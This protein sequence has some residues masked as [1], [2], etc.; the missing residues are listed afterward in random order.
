MIPV[1]AGLLVASIAHADEPQG[2]DSDQSSESTSDPVAIPRVE[3]SPDREDQQEDE[4]DASNQSDEDDPSD[5]DGETSS[6]GAVEVPAVEVEANE[7]TQQE[8]STRQPSATI[9][10]DDL[11]RRG[12]TDLEEAMRWLSAGTPTSPTDTGTGLIVDGLPASQVTVL[13]NGLPIS[14]K[15]GTRGGPMVDLSAI[16][17][18]PEAVERIEGYRGAGPAGSGGAGGVVINIVTRRERL[19]SVFGRARAGETGLQVHRRNFAAGFQLPIGDEWFVAAHGTRDFRGALDVNDDAVVD[20]PRDQGWSARAQAAWRPSKRESLRLRIDGSTRHSD[21][22]GAT[23]SPLYDRVATRTLGIRLQGD[24][25]PGG[26]WRIRHGTDVQLYDHTFHK[27]VR[28]SGVERLNAD[29]DQLRG[30]QNLVATRYFDN[31]D[32]NLELYGSGRRVRWAGES[33]RLAPVD[34][35]ALGLGVADTFYV[36]DAFRVSGRAYGDLAT[37]FGPGWTAELGAAVDVADGWTVKSTLSRTRRLPSAEELYLF[38]DH[39]DIGYQIRGNEALDPERLRSARLGISYRDTDRTIRARVGGFY[40]RS[41]DLV[42]TRS[43]GTTDGGVTILQYV[44][45]A[46]AHTAGVNATLKVEQLPGQVSLQA[47]YSFLPLSHDRETGNRLSLRSVH[48]G[49]LEVR[50]DFFDDRLDV[51]ADLSTRS[52][53]S[54]PDGAV[55]APAYALLGLGVR[56]RALGPFSLTVDANNLLDQTNATWGPKPGFNLLA[57]LEIRYPPPTSD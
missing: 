22:L 55:A 15:Q 47:N 27:I 25:R 49:R 2:D 29:T 37:D 32:L 24:W 35:G 7:N 18:E 16:G 6:D 38:F 57:T 31:H 11:E 33:G 56:Y 42:S 48:S 36:T 5:G 9:D 28:S 14:R 13:E 51:W 40:H 44:N 53:L 52:P 26:L 20:V 3:E 43:T 50:R 45:V 54:V 46:S 17:I 1:L 10:A 39:S 4:T 23:D 30:V 34:R 12:V 21:A 41:T 8:K 19:T